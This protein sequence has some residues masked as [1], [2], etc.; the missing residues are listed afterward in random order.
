MES[1]QQDLHSLRR[2]RIRTFDGS[3]RVAAAK[4][5]TAA[6]SAKKAA[7]AQAPAEKLD[8]RLSRLSRMTEYATTTETSPRTR[9]A[10]GKKATR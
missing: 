3:N 10:S 7:K 2:R 5:T 4:S 6:P 9:C 1:W 8:R